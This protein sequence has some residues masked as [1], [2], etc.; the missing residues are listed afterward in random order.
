MRLSLCLLTLNEIEG[1]KADVPLLER[2]QFDEVFAVDG[3]SNDGTREYLASQGIAV[4]GQD[5][6]GYN[7]AYITA[8]RRCTTDA[9]VLYHPKGSI[10]PAVLARFRPLFAAG[11]D[12][13]ISRRI[14]PGAV[15][16]EDGRFLKPRKWFVRVLAL[17]TG[18]LWRRS[19]V[20]VRDVLHGT[21]GMRKE[22]FFAIDPLEHGL[23]IDLEMVARA[24]RAEMRCAEF[25]VAERPRVAGA[26]HFKAWP[27]G[28]KL[29]RYLVMELGRAAPRTQPT[30]IPTGI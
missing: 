28:K 18:L 19:G 24:Y 13:V 25:P 17:I 26:T 7:G 15:N 27:T 23:S 12:L 10:D 9:L 11:N 3:G 14:G 4:H 30:S 21:R 20:F 29:L 16:E 8:F 2:G 5:I 6:R 22:A 1:C